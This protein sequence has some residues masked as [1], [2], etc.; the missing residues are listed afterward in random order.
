MDCRMR[1]GRG[2]DVRTNREIQS[3]LGRQEVTA[4]VA[5]FIIPRLARILTWEVRMV[6]LGCADQSVV[7]AETPAMPYE[8][9]DLTVATAE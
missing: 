5:K 7:N 2:M 8:S 3:L 1:D 4:K 9:V 6:R